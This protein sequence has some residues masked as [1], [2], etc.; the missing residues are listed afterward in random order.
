LKVSLFMALP[1]DIEGL[2][3]AIAAYQA[4]LAILQGIGG[5]AAYNLMRIK[6]CQDGIAACNTA[7]T[8][9]EASTAAVTALVP[10]AA[11]PVV[12]A[13]TASTGLV[14]RT[15]TAVGR[16]GGFLTGTAATVA[17]G[18]TVTVAAGVLV[19]IL[20]RLIGGMAA[21][22]PVEPGPAMQGEHERPATHVPRD[23]GTGKTYGVW[24][25]GRD[26]LVGAKEDLEATPCGNL[27]GWGLDMSQTVKQRVGELQNIG[28][29]TFKTYEQAVQRYREMLDTKS[30][31]EAPLSAGNV[32]WAKVGGKD[33]NIVNAP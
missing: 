31:H 14:L 15:L 23:G 25:A 22:K 30:V 29:E 5:T 4:E 1:T 13:G 19:Y 16:V 10:T 21:D 11:A 8:S 20:A 6:V 33:Y 7:I 3:S 2:R 24:V 28:G 18:V 26:V 12:P 32:V 17:G 27:R 9:L